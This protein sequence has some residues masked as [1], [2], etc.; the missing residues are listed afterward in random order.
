M[1]KAIPT[2][3]PKSCKVKSISRNLRYYYRN[4][5]RCSAE[6]NA[7]NKNRRADNPELEREK[8]RAYFLANKERIRETGRLRSLAD[9]EA[10]NSYQREWN[11]KNPEKCSAHARA[12]YNKRR[13]WIQQSDNPPSSKD[14][15]TLL[16]RSV[17]CHYCGKP[18]CR[19][20]IK[21]I[22]H[23]L[24][25]AKGGK[26]ELQNLVVACLPCNSSKSDCDP[27]EYANRIGLLF[28]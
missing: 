5:S 13:E 25:R 9:R 28:I 6:A 8:D 7:R 24:P 10:F 4:Q 21:S 19:K 20:R 2:V 17:R 18:F 27:I 14:I 11:A 23:V 1:P 15:Q 22:D 26:H 12:N 3:I 16:S